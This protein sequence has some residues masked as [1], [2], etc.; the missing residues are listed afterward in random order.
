MDALICHHDLVAVGLEE[1]GRRKTRR[2]VPQSCR[3]ALAA[4]HPRRCARHMAI[5][6]QHMEMERHWSRSL[7]VWGFAGGHA[8]AAA[9]MGGI[10]GH[11][12]NEPWQRERRGF[13]LKATVRRAVAQEAKEFVAMKRWV[14]G[15]GAGWTAS[16]SPRTE[17]A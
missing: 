2:V 8:G 14:R 5:R 3:D 12:D 9:D 15:A 11:S 7:P 6:W 1:H 17:P 4:Q 13:L 10:A 16:G